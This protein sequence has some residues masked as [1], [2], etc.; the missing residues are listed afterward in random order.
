MP[1]AERHLARPIRGAP[2][3]LPRC[4]DG[5]GQSGGLFTCRLPPGHRYL[6]SRPC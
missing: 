5:R 1:A 4:P 6:T 2:G 3:S